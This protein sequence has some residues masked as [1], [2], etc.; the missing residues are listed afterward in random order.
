MCTYYKL[1]VLQIAFHMRSELS[2]PLCVRFLEGDVKDHFAAAVL[3]SG[4]IAIWDLLLGHC[5]ALLP[6]VSDQNWSFVKW[7]STDSHLLAGQKDG[8][9]F[10]YRCT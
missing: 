9:I 10:V 5:T 8:N 2:S 4:T 6:P 3:T 7:S 1:V